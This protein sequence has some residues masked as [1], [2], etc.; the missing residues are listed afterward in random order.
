MGKRFPQHA[1]LRV[2]TVVPSDV[3]VGDLLVFKRPEGWVCHRVIGLSDNG[4]RCIGDAC[5]R[6]EMVSFDEVIGRVT[7]INGQLTGRWLAR[8]C[9]HICAMWKNLQCALL[10]RIRNSRLRFLLLLFF[11]CW[12]R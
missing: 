8:K 9:S 7:S 5:Y 4:F 6:G 12:C 10:A 1:I 11:R 2:M 3:L